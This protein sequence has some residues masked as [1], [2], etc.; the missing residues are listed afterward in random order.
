MILIADS[1]STKTDW[2]LLDECYNIQE[3]K[4]IGLNPYFVTSKEITSVLQHNIKPRLDETRIREVFFYGSGCNHEEKIN[5]VR[6]ALANFFVNA[7][8][9]IGPDQLGTARALCGDQAGIVAILGTGSNSC[10][11][12]GQKIT[13]QLFSLGYILGDE[14]SGAV[15]G[16][17][18]LKAALSE[19]MPGKLI[20]EFHHSFPEPPGSMLENIYS[21]P[22]PNRYLASFAPFAIHRSDDAWMHQL[23]R[24]HLI[25]FFEHMILI[26]PDYQDYSLNISGSIAWHLRSVI[27]DLCLNYNIRPGK[28][29]QRPIEDLADYHFQRYRL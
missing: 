3:I 5:E 9:F 6:N 24:N 16:K 1:G 15:L 14:G 22:F 17:K 23:L 28:I 21:K 29:I 12:D 25:D 27:L 13:H 11:Y 20:E 10:V 8:I 26:Y 19:T 2:I 7:N 4:T 18:I